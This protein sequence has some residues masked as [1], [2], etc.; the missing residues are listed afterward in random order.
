VPE[1][2]L[3]A[4]ELDGVSGERHQRVGRS[5]QID[6]ER[7]DV[8]AE[9]EEDVSLGADDPVVVGA[10]LNEAEAEQPVD[11]KVIRR[12][13]GAIEERGTQLFVTRHE[14]EIVV[15]A[16]LPP[17]APR[18][19]GELP[20]LGGPQRHRLFE[21]DMLPGFEQGARGTGMQVRRQQDV[22]GVAVGCRKLFDGTED[23]RDPVGSR[24]PLRSRRR[25]IAH[26]VQRHALDGCERR[27]MGI[28][29]VPGPEESDLQSRHLYSMIR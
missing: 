1:D 13:E 18:Q 8:G 2:A 5:E 20:A 4:G 26:G 22:H 16:E 17:T 7:R 6:D 12:S 21:E 11:R 9:L 23:M 3:P 15:D 19:V 27:C 29:D 25:Q 10:E 14:Q 24:R 28:Q